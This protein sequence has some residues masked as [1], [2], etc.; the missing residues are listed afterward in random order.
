MHCIRCALS[1]ELQEGLLLFQFT[2]YKVSV[3]FSTKNID[4]WKLH[5]ESQLKSQ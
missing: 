3:K 2:E 1:N 4:L 5:D